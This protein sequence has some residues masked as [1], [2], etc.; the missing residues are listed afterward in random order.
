[1]GYDFHLHS[2]G[3][4]SNISFTPFNIHTWV[5]G[6]FTTL[7]NSFTLL[8]KSNSYFNHPYKNIHQYYF[9]HLEKNVKPK[10]K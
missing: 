9:S 2:G 6:C 1:M 10:L 7:A 5:Y 4:F 3:V 8:K